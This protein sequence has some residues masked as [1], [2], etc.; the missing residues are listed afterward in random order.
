MCHAEFGGSIYFTVDSKTL[1]GETRESLYEEIVSS[2][3]EFGWIADVISAQY[4]SRE[5]LSVY[6]LLCISK[7][8][9]GNQG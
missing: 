2:A 7:A 6:G 3:G 5:M 9:T 4:I 8:C 1:S